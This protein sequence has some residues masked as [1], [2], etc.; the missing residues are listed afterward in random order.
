MN[1]LIERL[2]VHAEWDE[3]H[4]KGDLS[5]KHIANEAADEITSLRQQLA[6]LKEVNDKWHEYAKNEGVRRQGEIATA[7]AKAQPAPVVPEGYVMVPVE[8]NDEMQVAGAQS[9]RFDT[10]VINKMWTGNAVYRAMLS[11]AQEKAE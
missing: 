6:E 3:F 9:I 2:R 4:I 1:E 8:P 5:K 10:T 11:A 7:L